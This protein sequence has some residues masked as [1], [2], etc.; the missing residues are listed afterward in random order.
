MEIFITP[1]FQAWVN[2]KYE[3]KAPGATDLKAPFNEVGGEGLRG[4]R[5]ALLNSGCALH[6]WHTAGG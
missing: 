4:V 2:V 1:R 5:S 6:Q 3:D